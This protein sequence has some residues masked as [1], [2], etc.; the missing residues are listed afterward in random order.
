MSQ[1]TSF[2]EYKKIQFGSCQVGGGGTAPPPV[3]AEGGKEETSKDQPPT[4]AQVVAQSLNY[5]RFKHL[6]DRLRRR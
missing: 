4:A 1:Y 6:D 5:Q 2:T 3:K